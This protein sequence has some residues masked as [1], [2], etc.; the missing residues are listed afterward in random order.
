[1]CSRAK[2]AT[3]KGRVRILVCTK[4]ALC[5]GIQLEEEEEEEQAISVDLVILIQER[6]WTVIDLISIPIS[7]WK[8]KFESRG[9]DLV[10]G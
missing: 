9:L 4:F 6:T 8:L 5:Y 3:G 10:S 7:P 2:A 1:M